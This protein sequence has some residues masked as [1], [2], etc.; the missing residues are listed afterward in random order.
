MLE[1]DRLFRR[2]CVEQRY[3]SPEQPDLAPDAWRLTVEL[4]PGC[5][6]RIVVAPAETH[7]Y[8]VARR[9]PLSAG[10]P[11]SVE[12]WDETETAEPRHIA[13]V[14]IP[15][16]RLAV[17]A[18]L[19]EKPRELTERIPPGE[20]ALEAAVI[21][22]EGEYGEDRFPVTEAPAVRLLIPDEPAVAW[23][24]AL[25]E[26]ED[27]RL[28]LDGHA[29]GFSTDAAT[30]SDLVSFCTGGATGHGRYASSV[31]PCNTVDVR[32]HSPTGGMPPNPPASVASAR[33]A[34]P[35]PRTPHPPDGPPPLEADDR[36][37][38]HRHRHRRHDCLNRPR[39]TIRLRR[40]CARARPI[41]SLGLPM[42]S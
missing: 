24:S 30:G 35:V 38:V 17:S 4:L 2:Q 14:R 40:H 13:M 39:Q 3:A 23:E 42:T 5:R 36:P 6:G 34:R 7:A 8:G 37:T 18:P 41:A 10:N 11:F 1:D 29:Y 22:G 15:S 20:Y 25:S 27:P 19:D 9:R 33:S 32:A 12:R 28:L 26:G 21:A 31:A 16:G